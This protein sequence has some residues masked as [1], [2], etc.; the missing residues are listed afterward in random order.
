MY[1]RREL[2]NR[3]ELLEALG[4][5]PNKLT[6]FMKN[7]NFPYS[8]HGSEVYFIRDDVERWIE[9]Q[10]SRLAD[11]AFDAIPT[12]QLI[13]QL[14]DAPSIESFIQIYQR[15]LEHSVFNEYITALA[16]RMGMTKATIIRDAGL[17]ETYGYQVFKGTRKPS[18]E[19][20]I[21]LA[22]GFQA[23][24]ELTQ[25]LLKAA[26]ER[27]LYPKIP[28]EAVIYYCIEHGINLIDTQN[29]LN[30]L[31]MQLIGGGKDE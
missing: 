27:E 2:L 26:E 10:E 13:V 3:S 25:R 7:R 31:S 30:S 22:F 9:Q 19:T 23:D 16:D 4:L 20:V 28:R 24:I 1:G 11:D 6:L 29:K 15:R 18:R 21:G 5:E 17:S 14:L 8:T 12:Q